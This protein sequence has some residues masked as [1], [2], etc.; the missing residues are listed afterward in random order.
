M[1]QK[2]ISRRA[3]GFA[4]E[5]SKNAALSA[6]LRDSYFLKSN[7]MKF[8]VPSGLYIAVIGWRRTVVPQS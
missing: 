3:A 4:E 5:K 7:S 1:K 8:I 2:I 6:A